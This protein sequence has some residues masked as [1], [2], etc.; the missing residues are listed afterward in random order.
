MVDIKDIDGLVEDAKRAK[1]Y[2]FQGKLIIHPIQIE[3]CNEVFTPT[4]EEI[5][6]AK[7]L[8][9]AFEEAERDGRSV[10]QFEG[11]LIDYPMLERAKRICEFARIIS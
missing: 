10:F 2:G 3:P 8:I 11:N 9:E 5:L 6:Y 1:A 4:E 7:R